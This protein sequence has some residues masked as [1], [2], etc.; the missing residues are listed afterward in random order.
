MSDI[1]LGA[2]LYPDT[3]KVFLMDGDAL[4]LN[5]D[6]LLPI[7]QKIRS[8]F[9]RLTRISS[10]ANGFN[11]IRRTAAELTALREQ[12]LSLIYMGLES[13]SQRVLDQCKKKSS[14]QDMVSAVQ[15]ARECG[16]KSS[17]IVL[18]GLGGQ[19]LSAEHIELTA[20]ALNQMKPRFV[21]FLSL[22]LIPGTELHQQVEIGEFN[23]I[24]SEQLLVE[25]YEILKRL[26][27]DHSIFR[28]NHASNYLPLEGRL[29]QDQQTL[30][31]TLQA[32]IQGRISLKPELFRGL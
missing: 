10:Y 15:Q 19:E 20:R 25:T 18:L 21:N 3:R 23:P 8:S 1:E 28:C 29:P 13:G 5:N 32:A 9:P 30:L 4:V 27:L 2:Q 11:I 26:D 16:I 14:V 12:K 22:M 7:L 6:R 17:V 24:S 31:T